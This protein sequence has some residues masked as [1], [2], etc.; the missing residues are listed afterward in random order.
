[1]ID[2]A[3]TMSS[4]GRVYFDHNATCPLRPEAR[5]AMRALLQESA[6]GWGNPSSPHAFGH[7]AR[8]ALEEARAE[9]AA[10]LDVAPREIVFVSG[11]TESDNLAVLGASRAWRR[12]RPDR[13]PGRLVASSVEHP[14]V[15]ESC[16]RLASDGWELILLPADASGRIDPEDFRRALRLETA[17]ASVMAANN[18]TGVLQPIAE[19]GPIARQAGVALHVDA[20][21]AAGRIPLDAYATGADF[22]SISS[23]KMGGP[24]GIGALWVRAEARLEGP[25]SGGGQ[26]GRRR[27]GT[28]SVLLAAGFAAAARAARLRLGE[29]AARAAALR[30]RLEA[31]LTGRVRGV[32][33]NGAGA[34][35]LPNTASVT[36]PGVAAEALVILLDRMGF[37]IS[38]GS[39]C[40]T[41]AA[42]PSHVLAA[43]GLDA[44]AIASTVRI[45]LGPSTTAAE[46]QALGEA[47]VGAAARAAPAGVTA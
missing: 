1:M 28:E 29:E 27:P 23:H 42:R 43:M 17:L 7:A 12:S 37:A 18:E 6:A 13:A 46:T 47:V 34:A 25:L 45:S 31:D 19:I 24:A 16:R 8:L 41:G 38:T 36:V 32:R 22:I 35:R 20:V 39:A 15:L 21:Q 5:A 33:I 26:E 44:A 30:D 11:G 9:V 10:L 14:A 4:T 40:S 2:C 3:S